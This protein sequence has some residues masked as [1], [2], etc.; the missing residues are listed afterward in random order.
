MS[1]GGG[2][3][4][5][6]PTQKRLKDSRKKGQVAKSQDLSSAMLLLVSVAVL[7][8]MG[9]WVS[10]FALTTVREQFT[11][12]ASFDGTLSAEIALS[13]LFMGI[14]AL[15]MILS[16]LFLAAWTV[17]LVVNF[18]QVGSI[19]APETIK[20]QFSKLNPA[21]G[22][23]NKFLKLRPYVEISK[24][25]VKM[26][27]TAVVTAYILWSA[28]NDIVRLSSNPPDVAV[29][30]AFSLVIRIGF[31]IGIAFLIIGGLDYILQLFLHRRDLRMSKHELKEE[32]KETEGNPLIKSQRRSLHREL[33]QQSMSA[34][35]RGAD[36]VIANPTHISVALRYDKEKDGAPVIVAK[37]ADLMAAQIRK[38]AAEFRVPV[39]RD[40][41]LA[42]ALFELEID[43]EIPEELFEA[44]AVVLRW[45]YGLDKKRTAGVG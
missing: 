5:E 2:E 7:W 10:T 13:R 11:F 40:V 6:Q 42:R 29:Q 3:K 15:L 35:V 44:V 41:P 26:I 37:G 30:Y 27:V 17:S 9:G 23:K 24:T 20:P 34:A 31:S 32:Y 25:V 43:D 22:F 4:T 19:F 36:V 18:L 33:L 45:V 1:D 14:V 12:A 21:E 28:R 8:V 38:L 39:T 16:P